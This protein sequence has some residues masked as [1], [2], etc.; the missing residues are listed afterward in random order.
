MM[1]RRIFGKIVTGCIAADVTKVPFDHNGLTFGMT[2]EHSRDVIQEKLIKIAD[3]TKDHELFN[4]GKNLHQLWL[5][6]HIPSQIVYPPTSITRFSSYFI[7][8]DSLD[9]KGIKAVKTFQRMFQSCS[10]DDERSSPPEKLKRRK[11]IKVPKGSTFSIDR[12]LA[13][14]FS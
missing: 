1:P 13:K 7:F 4:K 5:Q 10:K 14:A 11:D 6:I 9:K 2:N 3:S 12:R 8:G